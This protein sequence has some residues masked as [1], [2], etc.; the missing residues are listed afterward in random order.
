MVTIEVLGPILPFAIWSLMEFFHDSGARRLRSFEVRIDVVD[1]H[2]QALRAAAQLRRARQAWTRASEHDPRVAEMHL[3]AGHRPFRFPIPVMLSKS[4]MCCQ[5][6]DP[7]GDALVDDVGEHGV[8]W[9]GAVPDM[10]T[11]A[12]SRRLP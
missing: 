2:G 7:V 10:D 9:Y 5:P 6:G 12:T 1:E 3:G 11:P 8:G 4:K